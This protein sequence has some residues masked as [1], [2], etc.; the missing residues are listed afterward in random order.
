MGVQLRAVSLEKGAKLLSAD[1]ASVVRIK[2]G[3]EGRVPKLTIP[4]YTQLCSSMDSSPSA[5]PQGP[6]GCSRLWRQCPANTQ[7]LESTLLQRGVSPGT[8]IHTTIPPP[9]RLQ[10]RQFPSPSFPLHH[11]YSC[12][13]FMPLSIWNIKQIR[14]AVCEIKCTEN[15]FTLLFPNTIAPQEYAIPPQVL[16]I[17]SVSDIHLSRSSLQMSSL[18]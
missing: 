4:R 2:L 18:W 14:D 12:L 6:R 9:P 11:D 5:D 8:I 16:S 1:V 7:G 13:F 15:S 3:W 17:L 10:L